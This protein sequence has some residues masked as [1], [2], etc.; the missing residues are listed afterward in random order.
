MGKNL[1]CIAIFWTFNKKS[2]LT[3]QFNLIFSCDLK[4]LI[5]PTL[6]VFMVTTHYSIPMFE[7]RIS[8]SGGDDSSTED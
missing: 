7:T 2:N 6:I 4:N 1:R 8:S 3:S 5:G